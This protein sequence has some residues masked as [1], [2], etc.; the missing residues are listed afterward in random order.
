[1]HGGQGIW[2]YW[3]AEPVDFGA[4][5][6]SSQGDQGHYWSVFAVP[7]PEWLGVEFI[8]RSRHTEFM[9][10]RY[11]VVLCDSGTKWPSYRQE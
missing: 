7:F 8:S 2:Q 5:I 3:V 10:N 1:M 9:L 4:R 6:P 11:E